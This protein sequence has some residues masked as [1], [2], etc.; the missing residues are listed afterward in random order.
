[1]ELIDISM[2]ISEE[3]IFYPGNPENRR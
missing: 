3:T 1:M 2:E